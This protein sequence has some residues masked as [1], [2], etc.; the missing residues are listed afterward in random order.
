MRPGR[1]VVAAASGMAAA[2]TAHTAWNARHLRRAPAVE[3][4]DDPTRRTRI[5]VLLPARDEAARIGP[6]LDGLLAQDH[7][8]MRVLILDDGS[9][10]GTERAVAAH[11]GHDPRFRVL[12]GG[13]DPL[14]EG[15][16]GKPWA[17][18][19]LAEAALAG[20]PPGPAP[21]GAGP[22]GAA[23]Q[24]AGLPETT[25]PHPSPPTEST[26]AGPDG[27]A[28]DLLVFLDADVVLAPGALTRIAALMA[29]SGLDLASPYPRQLA[30]T[31]AERLV[32]P[33]LQW[34]WL[35]TLP[36]PLAERSPRPSLTAANGQ[37]LAITPA[38]HSRIGGHGAVRAE[39]LEDIGLARAVKAAGGRATVTDGT[40]LATCR[41][42]T[43]AGELVDGYTKSLWAAFG[44][45]GGSAGATGL[46]TFAY[47]LPA[48][49]AV[50]AP[51]GRTRAI[52]AA[53]YAAGVAGRVLV[54]RRTG[55]RPLDGL[56]HPASILALDAL[57]GLSWRRHRRGE[58]A[59]K[60]RAVHTGH[61]QPA[62][63]PRTADPTVPATD[64]TRPHPTHP[65]Q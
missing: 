39:V 43:S 24:G 27:P 63:G 2:L 49:A 13:D 37:V 3:D 51:T 65:G 5:T 64:P 46:L 9:T 52:G 38:M 21:Q 1:T 35:T 59:W 19:R 4:P 7:P 53:G 15:W 29:D 61:P 34:S 16:L 33:L 54:A 25:Q 11:V 6:C 12:D 44:S 14:P 48:A 10:D 40:D 23:P 17:C 41:M 55:G 8:A 50:A 36:L 22:Q 62:P 31:P 18:Q 30:L 60:G 26:A 57:T 45:P 56:A 58:L 42:Y 47:V 20:E 32:Q 28:P